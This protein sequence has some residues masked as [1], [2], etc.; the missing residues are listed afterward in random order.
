LEHAPEARTPKYPKFWVKFVL[1][2]ARKGVASIL[3]NT[4][5]SLDQGRTWSN[6]IGQYAENILISRER[7]MYL[8]TLSTNEA[9]DR[10]R[11]VSK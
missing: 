5:Y 3:V 2:Q 10:C 11:V 1:Y 8:E 6:P 7:A 4:R 9:P